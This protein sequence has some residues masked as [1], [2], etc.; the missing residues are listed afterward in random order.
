MKMKNVV[1]FQKKNEMIIS[2][3]LFEGIFISR[4]EMRQYL[5]NK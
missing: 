1:F 3:S 5:L 4:K 2:D